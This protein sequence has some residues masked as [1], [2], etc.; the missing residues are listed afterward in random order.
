[1]EVWKDIPNYEGY[2]QVSNL[3][4]VKSLERKITLSNG[5]LRT[6][7]EKILKI[8]DNGKGYFI[9]SLSIDKK[10]KYYLV[11]QLVAMAFLG[12][13]PNGHK[14]VVDHINNVKKDNRLD[15]LQIIT[16][17]ENTS[18]NTKQG[19]SIYTGVYWSKTL[20]K[21]C[22]CIRINS[23]SKHLGYFDNEIDAHNAYQNALKQLLK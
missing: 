5:L 8:N 18:K 11:H 14:S 15:N 12:H 21:W 22:A 9:A 1:M 10:T 2:Y 7:N 3:G 19:S 13:T 17:R 20:N 16:N 6:I 4:N 23:K